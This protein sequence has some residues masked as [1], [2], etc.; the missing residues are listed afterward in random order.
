MGTPWMARAG[1]PDAARGGGW[2]HVAVSYDGRS[3]KIFLNG[4]AAAIDERRPDEPRE[5]RPDSRPPRRA[6]SRLGSP[7]EAVLIGHRGLL[8]L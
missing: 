5:R 8:L 1:A 2:V 6:T 7:A 4:R 3:R